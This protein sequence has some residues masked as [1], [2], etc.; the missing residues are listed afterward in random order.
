MKISLCTIGS[1]GDVLPFLVLARALARRGHEVR[2]S[3]AGMYADL[4]ASV[5][6]DY[7][8]FPGDYAALLDQDAMK[9]VLGKNPFTIGRRL[10]E[11]V[12]PIIESSLET[13]LQ[14]SEWADVV[15]YHP[16]ALVDVFGA[17]FPEKL[18]KAYVVPAFT[19]T[20]AFACPVFSGLPIPRLLRRPSYRLATA[21]LST[22]KAPIRAFAARHG[23]P[24]RARFLE[25]PTL[26]GIS[27][28]FLSR[29][30]DYPEDHVFS[31]FWLSEPSGEALP[32]PVER[33]LSTG[34]P[35]VVVT[36]G[37]M[38]YRCPAPIDEVVRALV[39]RA[40]VQVLV[41]RAWGLRDAPIEDGDS[42]VA[43]DR[44]PYADVFPRVAAVVHHGGAGTTAEACRA[45]IPMVVCPV[46]DPFGDQRFWGRR[47]ETLGIAGPTVPLKKVRPD[48]LAD[49]VAWLLAGD[50]PR[51]SAE[52]GRRVRA[53][54]GTEA[55]VDWI[56]AL[57]ASR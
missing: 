22:V 16:K 4:A 1:T 32:D 15:V 27:P 29:P 20:R 19:P 49:S 57:R 44:L 47:A 45:G 7:R 46:L 37:S 30:D 55:A 8:P 28:S 5:G 41:V 13:F 35:T 25:S 2:A 23:L 56:E 9:R 54:D 36:F 26:Y 42:V 14:E 52:L 6:V 48:A 3:S 12:Y 21:L 39:R 18:V 43:V 51:T 11:S 53:E 40:D 31:G 17:R 50:A 10:R 24:R 38:P 34:H 33:L